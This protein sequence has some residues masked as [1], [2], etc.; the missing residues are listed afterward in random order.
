MPD[1]CLG[2][3]LRRQHA[4]AI[5]EGQIQE[6]IF[7]EFTERLQDENVVAWIAQADDYEK[8]PSSLDP[9]YRESTGTTIEYLLYLTGS[10]AVY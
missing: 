6:E 8:D 5:K 2:Q 3:L 10:C 9:Y 7:K 1:I 4:E